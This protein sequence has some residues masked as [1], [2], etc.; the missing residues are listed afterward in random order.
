M[1]E[2]LVSFLTTQSMQQ[3]VCTTDANGKSTCDWATSSTGGSSIGS[4]SISISSTT[5]TSVSAISP[6]LQGAIQLG[7]GIV[8]CFFG[9]KFLPIAVAVT[10]GF[11]WLV[12]GATI[13][14]V[15]GIV[16]GGLCGFCCF[17]LK[18]LIIAFVAALTGFFSGVLVIM[19]TLGMIL[20]PK[21]AA[22][23]AMAVGL[24]VG[25]FAAHHTHKHPDEVLV[26]VTSVLG[27]FCITGGILNFANM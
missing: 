27:G 14:F 5:T 21:T 2:S 19:I 15:V 3:L 10:W 7:L 22:Y 6:A 1:I 13:N 17:K 12:S 18:N 16:L 4:G 25:G 24:G 20:D 8:Y 9:A 11:G 23:I 26:Y